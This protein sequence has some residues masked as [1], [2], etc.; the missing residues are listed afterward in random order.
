MDYVR[1][2]MLL[3]GKVRNLTFSGNLINFLEIYRIDIF[4]FEADNFL[5]Y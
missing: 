4:I 2:F 1:N 5:I 3:I